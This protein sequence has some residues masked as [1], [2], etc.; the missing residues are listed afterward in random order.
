M[1]LQPSHRWKRAVIGFLGHAPG[2]KLFARVRFTAKFVRVNTVAVALTLLAMALTYGSYG[3]MWAVA[4]TW[5]IGHFAWSTT[6]AT[7][8]LVGNPFDPE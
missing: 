1:T 8:V 4:L 6:V 5:T 2:L 7:W 3:T